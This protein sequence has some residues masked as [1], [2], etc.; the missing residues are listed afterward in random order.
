MVI[1]I[2]Y[3]CRNYLNSNARFPH[4]WWN[5]HEVLSDSDFCLT[6]NSLENLNGKLKLKVGHGYCSRKKAY[7]TLKTFHSEYLCQYTGKVVQNKMPKIKKIY[8]DREAKLKELLDKFYDLT[9][10]DQM[11]NLEYFC[12]EFGLYTSDNEASDFGKVPEPSLSEIQ[13]VLSDSILSF[14]EVLNY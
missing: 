7:K 11:S 6:T 13:E 5:Y 12:T 3:L 1:F 9:F 4:S 14:T 8:L 2:A 10:E